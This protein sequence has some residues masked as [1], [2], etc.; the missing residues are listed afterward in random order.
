M[1]FLVLAAA[2]SLGACAQGVFTGSVAVDGDG[3]VEGTIGASIVL[4]AIPSSPRIQ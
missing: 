2:I 4:D 3:N 1:K